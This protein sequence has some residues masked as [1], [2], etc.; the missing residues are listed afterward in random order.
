MTEKEEKELLKLVRANN[1]LLTTV[2]KALHLVPITEKEEQ[3]LQI[4]RRKN[5]EQAAKVN[6][7]L[8]AMEGI[9][10]DY[11]ENT[12]GNLFSD[13]GDIYGD[14][15]TDEFLGSEVK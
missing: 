10:D 2:A 14:I 5:E 3:D 8:N 11:E 9:P 13:V 1:R 6:S 4:M 15:L 7:Q 12:L